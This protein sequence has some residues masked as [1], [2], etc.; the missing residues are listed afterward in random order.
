[1]ADLVAPS[2]KAPRRFSDLEL[3]RRLERTEGMVG[4]SFVEARNAVSQAAAE[5]RVFDGTIAIYDGAESPFSQTFG[6]GLFGAADE[7][8]LAGVERFFFERKADTQHEV[9]PFAG[10]EVTA[11]LVARGY[12]PI[13]LST[14]L[15]QSIPELVVPTSP[16]QFEVRVIDPIRDGDVWVATSLAGWGS[17]PG[18]GD[19]IRELLVVNTRNHAMTHYLVEHEGVPIS[20]GSLGVHDGV[21]LLAGA[22]TIPSARGRGAQ[23]VLLAR[24]LVDA[25]ARGCELAM[26]VSSVG[27]QSQRNAERIGF[28]VAYTRTKWKRARPPA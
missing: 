28:A 14:V 7:E 17:E 3:S 23:S 24:R 4:S 10:I 20:T 19:F 9:S 2:T 18:V 27:S 15:V 22:S 6:L 1:M 13:E 25:R 26:I 16:L 21:A 12:V 11:R 5:A 8:A